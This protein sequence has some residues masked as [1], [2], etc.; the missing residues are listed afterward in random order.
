MQL[1]AYRGTLVPTLG[2][3]SQCRMTVMG[4]E[5]WRGLSR[6]PEE[7]GGAGGSSRAL[8]LQVPSAVLE[9]RT[10]MAARGEGRQATPEHRGSAGPLMNVLSVIEKHTH[11]R[12]GG[13]KT[14]CD[15]EDPA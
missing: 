10:A 4:T 7:T 15:R 3:L 5:E 6:I 8:H 12:G 11:G 9:H 1:H 13:P 14:L 2:T